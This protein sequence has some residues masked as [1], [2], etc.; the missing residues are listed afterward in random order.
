MNRMEIG[1]RLKKLRM[2]CGYPVSYV[3]RECD[4]SQ[5]ALSMYETGERLPRDEVKVRLANFY[6]VS[7]SSIFF[8]D[9]AHVE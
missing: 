7:V 8:D 6:H 1:A 4:I 2:D 5:S 3:A 9:L